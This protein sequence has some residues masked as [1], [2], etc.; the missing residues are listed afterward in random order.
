MPTSEDAS[1]P[2]AGGPRRVSIVIKAL[3]EERHIDRAIRSALRAIAALGPQGGE[4]VLADSCSTDRTVQVAARHPIRIVQ[5]AHPDERCCGVGPQLGYQFTSGEYVYILDGDMELD[6][7]FLVAAVKFLD[8]HPEIGGVGGQV[9]ETNTRSLEYAARAGRAASRMPAGRVQH[10]EMGG[11]YRRVAI[12]Q[13]GYF[14]DRNLHSYEE[15]DLALRL[16]VRGWT[17]WRLPMRSVLHEGHDAPALALL[18]RRWRS[19]Y[20]LGSGELLRA[21]CGQPHWLLV[22]RGVRELR[23]YAAVIAWWV[24]LASA[25]LWPLGGLACAAGFLLLLSVPF[26]LMAWRTRS[27]QKAAFSVTSWCFHAAGLLRG[28]LGARTPPRAAVQS[29]LVLDASFHEGCR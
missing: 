29:T 24:L 5:L 3:N 17:L 1:L 28:L 15:M 12:E 7:D 8:E 10:L 2:G 21:A 20:L 13:A 19:R 6:A 26:V 27:L 18:R 9:V 4:V 11:L 16:R 25:P 23:L 14:S 22:L